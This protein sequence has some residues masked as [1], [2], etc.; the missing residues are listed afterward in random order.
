MLPNLPKQLNADDYRVLARYLEYCPIEW[1]S[2]LADV[3][4]MGAKKYGKDNWLHP[5]GKSK[6]HVEMHNSM[7][8]HIAESYTGSRQDK[9]STLDPLKHAA[10]RALMSVSLY[11][12]KG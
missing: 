4:E 8:H 10:C 6:S 9:E 11:R 1:L 2:F 12:H 7:F 3:M 5:N